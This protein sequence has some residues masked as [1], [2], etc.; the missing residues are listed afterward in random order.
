LSLSQ[1]T[2]P[3]QAVNGKGFWLKA[4]GDRPKFGVKGTQIVGWSFEDMPVIRS[5]K[6]ESE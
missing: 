4:C 5:S 1:Q 6:Y 3:I 2:L